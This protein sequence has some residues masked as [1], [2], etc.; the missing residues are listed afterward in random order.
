M[1]I[2]DDVVIQKVGGIYVA[3]AVGARAKELPCMIKLNETGAFLWNLALEMKAVDASALSE[4]LRAE[5]DV[6]SEVAKA[7][8]EK[9]VKALIDNGL[10][11]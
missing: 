9:F 8:T 7:D 2:K 11:E 4:A 3:V 6:P 1:K 10:V 5:Y